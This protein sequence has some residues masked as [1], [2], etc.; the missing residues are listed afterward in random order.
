MTLN[1]QNDCIFRG[2]ALPLPFVALNLEAELTRLR[3]LPRA[4]GDDARILEEFWPTYRAHLRQLVSQGGSVRVR[5]QVIDPLIACS[6]LGYTSVQTAD[7]V[8]TREGRE[9]GGA[10]LIGP[11]GTFLRFWT[12]ALNEDLDAPA[13]R[14]EAYRFSHSR[15]ASR[16]LLA[17][18]ERLGLL[19]N[20][21]ELR[22]IICDPAR[23][24]SHVSIA[25]DGSWKRTREIPD[26]LR[27]FVALAK[28][29]GVR[30]LPELIEKARLQ[31]AKVTKDLRSQARL[32]VEE[33]IQAVIDH[34]ENQAP[35]TAFP[36]PAVLA[37]RLWREGLITVY[38]L[39]FTL[40]LESTDDPAKCFSF[41]SGSL[42]R[43][44][45]SPGVAL[46]PL[47]RA[48]LD[49][50]E[51]T[52]SM[53]EQGLRSLFRMLESGLQ[54]TELN[55]KPMGGSLFTPQATP[56]LSSLRW[57]EHGAARLLDR[58][59]WTTP[60]RGVA[61]RERVHY[62]PLD[63]EDLGRVYEALLELDPGIT[64]EPMCRLRR[65]KLEVVVPAEQGERY[66][67]A[68]PVAEPADAVGDDDAEPE[69]EES[70]VRTKVEWIEEI[71][72]RRFYLRVGL[73]RKS[74]GSFYTPHSFVRFLV[75][76]T[77]GPLVQRVSPREDPKP[78]AILKLKVVDKAMGSGHFLVEAARFLGDALYEAC[79]SCD[80][81]ARAASQRAD[82][83]RAE[84]NAPRA[85]EEE[86]LA[87]GFL[88]RI[89]V[90]PDPD[91]EL[92][93]YLPSRSVEGVESGFSQQKA[94]ALCRRMAAVHCI[95]GVDK[96]PLAVELAKLALWIE[97]HAEGLP[98]TFLDHRLVLG[99]SLT[100][101]FFEHLLKFPGTQQP[102]NDLFTSGLTEK[103]TTTLGAAL[104]HV[105]D[106]EATV[107]TTVADI[108]VKQ[109]AKVRL[110]RA[111]APFRLLSAAW[112]GGVML[113]TGG[114]DD[115]AYASLV[116]TVAETG[117]LPSQLDENDVRLRAMI[118]AGLGRPE[119]PSCVSRD[120]VLDQINSPDCVPG[121]SYDLCFPEVF[122]PTGEINER[123][124]FDADLGNPPWDAIQFKS[125][126]FLASFDFEILNTRTGRERQ[127]IQTHVL[128]NEENANLFNR[129][130]ES[131]ERTKRANDALYSYQKIYIDG[132]LA[133]R[134]LDAFRVFME[135]TF[136]TIGTGGIA[137]CVVPSAFHANEGAT[138]VRQLY[139]HEMAI[140]CCYSF[141][142]RRKLFEIDSRLKFDVLVA[143]KPGPSTTFSCGFYLH[144]D[145]WLF[146]E[147]LTVALTYDATF[148]ESANPK[149]L[150]F[151]ELRDTRDANVATQ[152]FRN[153]TS[154]GNLIIT[155]EVSF[156]R[157]FDVG[158]QEPWIGRAGEGLPIVEGKHF[159]QFTDFWVTHP[160]AA[161]ILNK[162]GS[163]N[164][165]WTFYRVSF[166]R[167]ASA[168]NERTSIWALLP[169]G[170]VGADSNPIEN[171]PQ[172]R[173]N[174]LV[175]W[176]ISTLN[177]FA[178]DYQLRL[179][180][181]ANV[182]PFIL[183]TCAMP[184]LDEHTR[185]FLCHSSLRLTTNHAGYEP[186][187][188]EQLGDAWR[189]AGVAFTW[190]VLLDDDARWSV[191]A[192]IDAVVAQA[193]GLTRE[194]YVH[195][196]S[197][198]SHSSYP[199]APNVCIAAFDELHR[200]ALETFVHHHDPYWDI[201]LN[202][203]LPCPV[204]QLTIPVETAV[205]EDGAVYNNTELFPEHIIPVQ[206]RGR[207]R[208]SQT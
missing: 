155:N 147:S 18:G 137:G 22:L 92:L 162:I 44:S 98:L 60:R 125:K 173:P 163:V 46:A 1:L 144:D 33:F 30:A 186:L 23:L 13:R 195:V 91:D 20:G 179:R 80:D 42:W 111:L 176:L 11:D 88:R 207:R 121:F 183:E 89:E 108:E 178:F 83:L 122:Y 115:T 68:T 7:E 203:V 188:R 96:N 62:G 197:T 160:P 110:D 118:A 49:H 172:S 100:G 169:P 145:E 201:P 94:V 67:P 134:Q 130:R 175:L 119:F 51:H 71:P 165:A 196:L 4:T 16:V 102:L 99:D 77:I 58:L 32:A 136:Q 57:P 85:E 43:N 87:L 54:C 159:H 97:C 177:T 120:E 113:G 182:N 187:W 124:G 72:P 45:F 103:L 34:P 65:A 26:S 131:F 12:T 127:A 151:L 48:V 185:R 161:L 3:L 81:L 17:S 78:A 170:V 174:A 132:D 36:N 139:L 15:I 190:P 154:F 142:N 82:A 168:T 189:E 27:L 146:R 194:Q 109:S 112:S 70:G 95:Y 164:P 138:G 149:Y 25:L 180:V 184:L 29:D 128:E 191:R 69:E 133:G 101:P 56:I 21:A 19:S 198:F 5:N 28:P 157:E 84:G 150:T 6:L 75:Q 93:R 143:E 126:E 55:V 206:P 200:D 140:H 152:L 2:P 153:R 114:C 63:V 104:L 204:I 31:Q 9:N 192:A 167:I 61:A 52:G 86:S 10:F 156:G 141:E 193:Y 41:A 181:G 158:A 199:G 106:L 166:R 79:R 123:H 135:R 64:S 35:L 90:L 39:L 8:Q 129:S 24:D 76:E 171:S 47:V 37:R 73:G 107:G 202:D 74:T 116:R 208:R 40:K 59:L 205:R 38:R 53:L 105:R 50:G 66:R 148:V 14:G 117:D